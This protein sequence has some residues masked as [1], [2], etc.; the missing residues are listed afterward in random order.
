METTK[1]FNIDRYYS[2]IEYL[3]K[4][5]GTNI[6]DVAR[7]INNADGKPEA[8]TNWLYQAKYNGT[9]PS[10]SRVVSVANIFNVSIDDLLFTDYA[11][12]DEDIRDLEEMLAE[13]KAKRGSY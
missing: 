5:N 8:P 7:R 13:L 11:K 4:C 3:C 9:T 1:K 6:N 10:I 2:N 12:I